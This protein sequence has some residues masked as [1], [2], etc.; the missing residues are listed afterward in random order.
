M[1]DSSLFLYILIKM[2]LDKNVELLQEKWMN[3]K[4]IVEVYYASSEPSFGKK[5]PKGGQKS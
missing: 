3:E 4:S 5:Q 2:L 1:D